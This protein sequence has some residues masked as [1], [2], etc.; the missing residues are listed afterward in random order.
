MFSAQLV[1]DFI[2]ELRWSG[3]SSHST[4]F[5][6]P[7]LLALVAI[8]T[9]VIGFWIGVIGTFLAL[10]PGARRFLSFC[11]GAVF[12]SAAHIAVPEPARVLA[13]RDRLREYR[14]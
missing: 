4:C 6:I 12:A 2:R 8:C 5:C 13:Q 3:F 10:S 11:F 9:G 7:S 1:L 14:A